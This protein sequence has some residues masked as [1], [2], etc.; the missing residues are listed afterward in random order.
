MPLK[1]ELLGLCRDG[2][3]QEH[4]PSAVLLGLITVERYETAAAGFSMSGFSVAE[5]VAAL[6]ER[7]PELADD[8]TTLMALA[9][10]Y[11]AE[12][13]RLSHALKGEQIPRERLAQALQYSMAAQESY[14]KIIAR[15]PSREM[16]L[17]LA[18][19]KLNTARLREQQG[20]RDALVAALND[21][22]D[23]SQAIQRIDSLPGDGTVEPML[24]LGLYNRMGHTAAQLGDPQ[25]WNVLEAAYDNSLAY[26]GSI[27]ETDRNL[28]FIVQVLQS[29][30]EDLEKT[31]QRKHLEMAELRL[32][33]CE[34]LIEHLTSR[35]VLKRLPFEERQ[36]LKRWKGEIESDHR[37]VKRA[38]R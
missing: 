23:A 17:A 14:G 22:F 38:L 27:P 29:Q 24:A 18:A 30:V 2:W 3:A 13:S 15:E 16:C 5:D 20:G 31:G 32:S 36:K 33:A 7:H 19:Q 4:L 26:A 35:E 12:S 9:Q 6:L 34:M 10:F 21:L 8:E 25:L 11:S 37:R 1:N 28:L